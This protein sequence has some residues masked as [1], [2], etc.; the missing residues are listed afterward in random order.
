VRLAAAILVRLGVSARGFIEAF[1]VV[2]LG[3]LLGA[4]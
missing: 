1:F 2:K 3:L 4:A